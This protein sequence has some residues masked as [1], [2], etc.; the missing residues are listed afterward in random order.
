MIRLN[1]WISRWNLESTCTISNLWMTVHSKEWRALPSIQ[2]LQLQPHLCCFL[3]ADWQR[4]WLR[5]DT[6]CSQSG[7]VLG[8]KRR[9]EEE[10]A[11]GQT[12][13]RVRIFI[14][15]GWHRDM[16]ASSALQHH[17]TASPDP[18]PRCTASYGMTKF[19]CRRSFNL[20]HQKSSRL[21]CTAKK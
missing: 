21:D 9:G 20:E 5:V 17:L 7:I 4:E 11:M 1:R 8:R 16:R 12:L 6:R 10:A 13:Y 19:W 3:V 2:S 14:M 18:S 15:T